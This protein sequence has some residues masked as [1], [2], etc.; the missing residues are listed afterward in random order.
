MQKK[1]TLLGL[2]FSSIFL[3]NLS[4]AYAKPAPSLCDNLETGLACDKAK[5]TSLIDTKQNFE[6]NFSTVQGDHVGTRENQK[7]MKEQV[8][9]LLNP[10][11][12]L[13]NY[14]GT[15]AVEIKTKPLDMPI[16][17]LSHGGFDQYGTPYS[18]YCT[19]VSG[20]MY[21]RNLF[22]VNK[23]IENNQERTINQ[24][25]IEV[26]VTIAKTGNTTL[27]KGL[28]P[29]IWMMPLNLTDTFVHDGQPWDVR[30]VWPSSMEIDI[31]EY[32][33]GSSDVIGTLH[34]GLYTGLDNP[35][36]SWNYTNN[37]DLIQIG[38]WMYSPGNDVNVP[39]SN[40]ETPHKLR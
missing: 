11:K 5:I 20:A 26:E 21:T 9:Y 2:A 13:S 16:S 33:Q 28:W 29:A 38:D 25:A 8:N 17:C 19:Y 14:S 27:T 3:S 37:K 40:P 23:I 18:D 35:L 15:N 30:N 31:L 39:N 36:T 32:M 34:Y 24:G 10:I 1:A 4:N 12:D 7:Y 22:T 6:K